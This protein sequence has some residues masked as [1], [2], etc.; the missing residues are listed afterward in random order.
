[1]FIASEEE[2]E[3]IPGQRLALSMKSNLR[4]W[5]AAPYTQLLVVSD[6]AGWSL[7]EDARELIRMAS[8]CQIPAYPAQY[9]LPLLRQCVHYTSFFSLLNEKAFR[10]QHRIS[11][12]YYHG[13]PEQGPEFAS[14]FRAI[15][16]H[17]QR[18]SKL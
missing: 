12:D 18:I 16:K 15:Q 3:M 7:D 13:K 17:S 14:V 10:S 8:Y 2:G 9:P 6:L 5:L 4:G 1:M 11:V